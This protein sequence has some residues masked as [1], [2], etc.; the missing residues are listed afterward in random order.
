M[1]RPGRT[2]RRLWLMLAVAALASIAWL[3]LTFA[4]VAATLEPVQRAAAFEL[5]GP[6]LA[7]V[8]LTWAGGIA[9]IAYGLKRWFDFWV[10]PSV[11]L[12]EEAQILL[13]TDVV[14]ELAPAGNPETRALARLFNQLVEQRE[15]L[16]REM[17]SK[18]HAAAQRIEEEKSRLAALMAELTQSVVVCNLDGRILLYNQRARAQFRD[19]APAGQ[20]SAPGQAVADSGLLGLGRSIHALFDRQLVEH[21]LE[22]VRQRMRR[23]APQPSAQFVT[24]TPAGQLL[25]V[26]LAPVRPT[27]GSVAGQDIAGYVLML[28]DVMPDYEQQAERD[29][30]LQTLTEGS[31]ASLA[32]I[33]AA[34]EMLDFPDL[35]PA[36]RERFLRVVRDEA[37]AMGERLRPLVSEASERLSSRWPMEDMLGSDFVTA[38]LRRIEQQAG[39]SAREAEVDPAAWLRI[40]SF[41]LLQ[42]LVY[43]AARLQDEFEVRFIQLRLQPAPTGSARVHLDLMWTGPA[44]S[45]ETVMGWELDPVRIGQESYSFSVRDVVARHGGALSFE[46]DRASHLSFFRF[47]LPGV[48]P[49]QAAAPS[50][51][52]AAAAAAEPAGRPEFYDFDLFSR[53]EQ[54]SALD[55]RP[56][57]DLVYTVFDTETTGL[58]PAGGDQ[59][60]Q[61]GAARIVNGKLLRQETFDQLVDPQC[62]IPPA[63]IPIHGI[64]QDM[65]RGQPTIERV[66]PA[67]HAF[68]RDTV[69]VGHNAAFD[70][71]FLQLLEPGTGIR[72]DQPVLDTL[73][74]SALVHPS[75]QSHRIEAI[76]QRFNLAVQG[77]HN[78][79]G[80]ALVTAEIFLR[81]I[82][83]L[84][85]K[86]IHTLGQARA[87]AQQTYYARLK[88]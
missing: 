5:I 56:L 23:G 86:G 18:V 88:Y 41:S 51:A 16:R 8:G 65:V 43:L 1:N 31:R 69:L 71:R 14:R 82:P 15:T 61:I 74:L 49:R 34:L 7:L 25:R 64:H 54:A 9:A 27:A 87:A 3:A 80:D 6:H 11:R 50:E 39:L 53:S 66:L 78:A 81:L 22:N 67:F 20:A 19:L 24:L 33:Q 35:E 83:L 47:L 62:M 2:D 76:A 32:S 70:L 79:L 28:D 73:L 55:E 17:D 4:L 36:M 26:Q 60:L 42:V 29:R 63:G 45:T 52:A 75:Q 68:A 72:F 59:I 84:A 44:I 30:A 58:N 38:A 21:A 57:L 12:A 40:E 46:R 48:A 85:E 37:Q 77:R 10:T 13:R